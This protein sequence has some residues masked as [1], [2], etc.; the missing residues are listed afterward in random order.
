[1]AYERGKYTVTTA[2]IS[3]NTNTTIATPGTGQ[4]IYVWFVG[5]DVTTAGTTSTAAF[6]DGTTPLIVFATTAVGHQEANTAFNQRD[7][8]G[9]KLAPDTSLVLTTAGGAAA[10]LRATVVFEVK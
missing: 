5:V 1:M 6:T 2:S 8:P 9:M 7:Y 3:S 4:S 10:T